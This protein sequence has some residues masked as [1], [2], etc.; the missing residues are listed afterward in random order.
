MF[1]PAAESL[2]AEDG[3]PTGKGPTGSS[4]YIAAFCFAL[5]EF[6]GQDFSRPFPSCTCR[7]AFMESTKT[8]TT[9]P[10]NDVRNLFFA[11]WVWKMKES[12]SKPFQQDFYAIPLK[13]RRELIN[14]TKE[15]F[16]LCTGLSK[17]SGFLKVLNTGSRGASTVEKVPSTV[18]SNLP[19]LSSPC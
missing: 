15:L 9:R 16:K 13:H 1:L 2:Y 14:A 11:H 5:E 12:H 10:L 8:E 3:C 7:L 17:P 6:V 4:K 18:S 19:P